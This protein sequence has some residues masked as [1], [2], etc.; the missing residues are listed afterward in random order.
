MRAD[1]RKGLVSKAYAAVAGVRDGQLTAL[2]TR[3][4]QQFQADLQAAIDTGQDGFTAA[5]A[6]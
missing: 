5:A 1:K 4:L 6:G 3:T 2:R